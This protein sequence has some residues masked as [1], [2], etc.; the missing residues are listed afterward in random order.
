MLHGVHMW[1]WLLQLYQAWSSSSARR[2]YP[3]SI[4]PAWM[5]K[6]LEKMAK[7]ILMGVTVIS[8]FYSLFCKLGMY[9]AETLIPLFLSKKKVELL[10]FSHLNRIRNS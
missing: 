2:A 6:A 5:P 8:F 3:A 10:S 7:K 4:P 9:R 1:C